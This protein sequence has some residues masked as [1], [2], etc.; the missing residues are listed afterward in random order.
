MPTVSHEFRAFVPRASDAPQ[1]P[2]WAIFKRIKYV[3]TWVRPCKE[4]LKIGHL[5][6]S[7]VVVAT[8]A[9]RHTRARTSRAHARASDSSLA[10]R[11]RVSNARTVDPASIPRRLDSNE[12]TNEMASAGDLL[13]RADALMKKCAR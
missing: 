13:A 9:G 5:A 2:Y 8:R 6:P 11:A 7:F 4:T 10:S 12:R 3:V 1:L